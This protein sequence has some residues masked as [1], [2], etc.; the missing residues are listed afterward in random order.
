MITIKDLPDSKPYNLFKNYYDLAIE[1][2]QHLVEAIAISSYDLKANL[3]DSRYVNLKYV[4][5]EEWIF[6][7]NY[8]SKKA[9]HFEGHNQISALI[10][11]TSINLQIRMSGKIKKTSDEFSNTHFNKRS[12]NKNA[13]AI[14]SKQ[15]SI[16]SSYDEVKSNYLKA[17]EKIDSKTERP[18]YWG[19]YTFTPYYFEYWLGDSNRLNKRD[20][21]EKNGKDEWKHFSIQP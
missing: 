4:L 8:Q 5:D 1:N 14:S 17:L 6:F 16:V 21:Y 18:D 19:G 7:S 11:W 20:V 15:S 2:K 13:L 12:K 9:K 10:H 3:V